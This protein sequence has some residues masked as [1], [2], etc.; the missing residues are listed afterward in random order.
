MKK[1]AGNRAGIFARRVNRGSLVGWFFVFLA[2]VASSVHV[3]KSFLQEKSENKKIIRIAHTQLE[4]GN[5]EALEA[6]AKEYSKIHPD[7]E[8]RQV[9][10]GERGYGSWMTTRLIG[11]TAPDIMEIGAGTGQAAIDPNTL[12]Q[13]FLR[14]FLPLSEEIIKPNPYNKGT[15]LENVPWRFTFYDDMEAG[16]I[17][18]LQDY[19][20]VP[21]SATSIRVFYNKA[22]LKETTGLDKPPEDFRQFLSACEKIKAYGLE[23]HQTLVPIA[24]SGQ[25]STYFFD[26]ISQMVNTSLLDVVD[27]NMDGEIS[28]DES[29]VA[30]VN[31]SVDFHDPRLKAMYQGKEYFMKQFQP[32]FFAADRTDA[33]FLFFQK[34]AVMVAIGIWDALAYLRE[35][36]F[37]VGI[38]DFPLPSKT[39]PEFG[40][41][42]KGPVVEEIRGIFAFSVTRSSEYPDIAL[43]FLKFMS[44]MRMNDL[45]NRI[46]KWVP[47]IR[48]N[49]PDPM[50]EAFWPHLDGVKAGIML[51]IG[52]LNSMTLQEITNLQFVGRTNFDDYMKRYQNKFLDYT[53]TYIQLDRAREG[54]IAAGQA[55]FRKTSEM[56]SSWLEKDQSSF[57]EKR[58][59]AVLESAVSRR[60]GETEISQRYAEARLHTKL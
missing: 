14:Y 11:K 49:V 19:Y 46:S 38:A 50:I 48:G 36:D 32:C 20:K 15:F 51:N 34:K 17:V 10:I 22:L 56:M 31:G 37:D 30:L 26:K 29:A 60:Q 54:R 25:N 40:A 12:N 27:N 52:S 41:F 21:A 53:D 59:L 23:H 1:K 18:A 35:V 57:H 8:I 39:D 58:A 4:P 3:L 7:V 42:V 47:M 28:V 16:Y 9:P 13:L 2:F 5:R 44:S 6:V 33:A 55:E 43:D 45:L 24:G